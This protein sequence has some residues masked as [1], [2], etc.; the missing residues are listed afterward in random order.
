MNQLRLV[1]APP[2]FEKTL[3]TCNA[4]VI[5]TEDAEQCPPA[6]LSELTRGNTESSK[7]EW[8]LRVYE[9]TD[10]YE[11]EFNSAWSFVNDFAGFP[12]TTTDCLCINLL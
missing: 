6:S 9:K 1:N 7:K 12:D 3:K 2:G 11:F 4:D 8:Q 5:L 10:L